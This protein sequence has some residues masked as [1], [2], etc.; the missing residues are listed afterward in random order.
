MWKSVVQP[1]RPDFRQALYGR[2]SGP[3]EESLKD[4]MTRTKSETQG[5]LESWKGR[6][7]EWEE[8]M[9]EAVG[10]EMGL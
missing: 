5:G 4:S 10:G 6:G 7:T 8:M 3:G 1:L 9:S 2:P